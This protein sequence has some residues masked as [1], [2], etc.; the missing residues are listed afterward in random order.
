[1]GPRWAVP[2]SAPYTAPDWTLISLILET[3]SLCKDKGNNY[4]I[5]LQ[6]Y[7]VDYNYS[8]DERV[9]LVYFISLIPRLS[10]RLEYSWSWNSSTNYFMARALRVRFHHNTHESYV[11][12]A[13]CRV[14]GTVKSELGQWIRIN[15]GRA[16]LK[17]N[18]D[19]ISVFHCHCPRPQLLAAH[20][21]AHQS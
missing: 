17:R 14:C 16:R 8:P 10:N 4:T 2:T 20:T 13:K 21:S 12:R 15:I 6:T 5:N 3:Y 7:Y 19:L 18:L 9:A 11:C 1:M